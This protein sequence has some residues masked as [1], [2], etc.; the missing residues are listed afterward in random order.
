MGRKMAG[1]FWL[2]TDRVA[3]EVLLILF[4]LLYIEEIDLLAQRKR[5]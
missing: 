1:T 4:V 3:M 5:N 2:H